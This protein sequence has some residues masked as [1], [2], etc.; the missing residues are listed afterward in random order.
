MKPA[1]IMT[2]QAWNAAQAFKM[3]LRSLGVTG[4]GH[5]TRQDAVQVTNHA[6]FHPNG[7]GQAT[8]PSGR[9]HVFSRNDW[10]RVRLVVGIRSAF[11]AGCGSG[12]GTRAS[13]PT[14]SWPAG[15]FNVTGLRRRY[16]PAAL[17]P[18]GNPSSATIQNPWLARLVR[19]CLRKSGLVRKNLRGASRDFQSSLASAGLSCI[20]K[21]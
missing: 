6:S 10:H 4:P 21:A 5:N 8:R 18:P 15:P 17:L 7:D 13:Q 16:R 12:S 20:Y 1:T 19:S 9:E 11:A 3:G 2:P 14:S